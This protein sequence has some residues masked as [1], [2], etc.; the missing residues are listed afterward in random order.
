MIL[1]RMESNK[2]ERPPEPIASANADEVRDEIEF[3][4]SRYTT[5]ED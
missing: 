3:S 4:A 5:L 1:L 2:L